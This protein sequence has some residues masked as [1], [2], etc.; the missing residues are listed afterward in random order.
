[1]HTAAHLHQ[2]VGHEELDGP[3][4]LDLGLLLGLL[5]DN[6]CLR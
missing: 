5:Q 6:V 1:M 4:A 2:G 3:L